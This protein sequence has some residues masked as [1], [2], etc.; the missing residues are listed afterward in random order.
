MGSMEVCR[1]IGFDAYVG[2][3]G[4]VVRF[5]RIFP[6]RE[7]LLRFPAPSDPISTRMRHHTELP[8]HAS[9]FLDRENIRH[10][11]DFQRFFQRHE[12]F[13]S[14]FPLNPLPGIEVAD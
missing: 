1:F 14:A 8:K 6:C 11:F 9:L 7:T 2:I 13:I 10:G 5:D 4:G 12:T 3:P